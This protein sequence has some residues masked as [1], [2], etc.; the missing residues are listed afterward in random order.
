MGKDEKVV[1][2]TT[3]ET[4]AGMKQSEVLFDRQI[5]RLLACK[6][7][8][9][10][11]LQETVEECMG[12]T[13]EEIEL[14]IEGNPQ[15]Q[16]VAVHPQGEKISGR[17]QE[18]S[19][20]GEGTVY[21]DIRTDLLLPGHGNR[22]YIKILVDVEAQKDD[23][24]GYDLPL[25]A[26]FYCCRMISSQLGSEFSNQA[27]DPVKYGNIKKVYSIWICSNTAE[28]RANSVDRY[29]LDRKTIIGDNIDMPRYDIMNA[30]V[31]NIG[32]RHDA[33]DE[34]SRMIRVL[35]DLL[36]PDMSAKD[37]IESLDYLGIGVTYEIKSEVSSMG[38]IAAEWM[39]HLE[40]KAWEKVDTEVRTKGQSDL[41]DTVL[42]LRKGETKEQLLQSG[43]DEKTI[44]LA[45]TLK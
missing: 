2:T 27:D 44:D 40:Q 4:I 26:L 30:I 1:L 25:R 28:I 38:S 11:I 23:K 6:P 37:K 36:N 16:Q 29:S 5:K 7:I 3:G 24:P 22:E 12:M 17:M 43:V 18:D 10:C 20:D 33:G 39:K 13:L 42:R 9:A 45:L 19:L 15:V 21:Y 34:Q 32:N 31:V 41:A 8:L 35:N 14:C